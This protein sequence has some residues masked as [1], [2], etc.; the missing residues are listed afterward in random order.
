MAKKTHMV[1]CRLSRYL[2]ILQIQR[3]EDKKYLFSHI[4]ASLAH[5][6]PAQVRRDLMM[7]GANGIPAR[8]YEIANLVRHIEKVL[9]ASHE[10]RLALVGVGNLGR[11]ILS[12]LPGR[13]TNLVL[14]AAFDTNPAKTGKLLHGVRC[15]S[16]DRL[17]EIVKREAID[18]AILTV[19][20]AV[21]QDVTDR[22]VQ[23]GIRGL[24][25]FTAV[26]LRVPR[27]IHVEDLDVVVSLEKIAY[28][29]REKA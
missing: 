21:A 15:F 5:V 26:A 18:I 27:K 28:L 29:V 16:L 4:L 11:A 3:A 10:H 19:P 9:Y 12:Y 1:I 6:T 25:N 17:D 13:M 14:A 20:A 7:V 8:G 23:N 2:S 22:L 24:L